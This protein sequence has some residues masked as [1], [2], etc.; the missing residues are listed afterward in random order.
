MHL[1]YEFKDYSSYGMYCVI[2]RFIFIIKDFQFT[3]LK[4]YKLVTFFS[5]FYV[6]PAVK[7]IFLIHLPLL[8]SLL[9]YYIFTN[10]FLFPGELNAYTFFKKKKNFFGPEKK[11]VK[12]LAFHDA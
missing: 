6:F 3:I 10:V 2:M 8:N 11:R 4:F 9:F 1:K 12:I 7:P 5:Y